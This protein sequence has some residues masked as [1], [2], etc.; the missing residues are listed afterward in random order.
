MR[1]DRTASYISLAMK[2]GKAASGE[3]A[4]EKSVKEGKACLMILAED[5]S[6]NTRKKFT[7]L[8]RYYGIPIFTYQTKETLG[9]MIGKAQRA[10]V[11]IED[12]G[13]A[14]AIEQSR[15]TRSEIN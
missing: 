14:G 7:D 2:A 5:A 3:Y 11:A 12:S 8:C 1:P 4:A 6:D 10:C 9:R 13:L 15:E